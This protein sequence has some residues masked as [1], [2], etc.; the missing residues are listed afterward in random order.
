VEL[1]RVTIEVG[2]AVVLLVHAVWVGVLAVHVVVAHLRLLGVR[3]VVRILHCH[4]TVV[5][6]LLSHQVGII[7]AKIL[8]VTHLSIQHIL[9]VK[10]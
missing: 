6:V 7:N 3:V 10:I 9:V 1:L 5:L 8:V 4:H 2:V